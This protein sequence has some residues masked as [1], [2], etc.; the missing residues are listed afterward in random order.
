MSNSR[1]GEFLTKAEAALAL[2]VSLKWL[3]KLID[4]GVLRTVEVGSEACVRDKDVRAYAEAREQ[5]R[6]ERLAQ[7]AGSTDSGEGEDGS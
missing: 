6:R 4:G 2:N 1:R 7:E 3:E 5:Y